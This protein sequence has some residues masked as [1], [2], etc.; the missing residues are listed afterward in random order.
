MPKIPIAQFKAQPGTLQA[1]LFENEHIAMPL[2]LFY[3]VHIPLEPFEIGSKRA[4]ERVETTFRLEFIPLPVPDW[5]QLGGQV[6]SLKPDDADGSLYLGGAHNPVDIREMHFLRVG[7][8]VFHL[9]CTVFCDFDSE[10]VSK[11]AVVQLATQIQFLGLRLEPDQITP[12]APALDQFRARAQTLVNLD[13][14][15][16]MPTITPYEIV[17]KPRLH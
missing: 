14:Y 11:N 16:S 8:G 7:D 9:D 12:T 4:R 13:A 6:F 10:G 15:E 2:S 3:D 1:R 17:F 5:R